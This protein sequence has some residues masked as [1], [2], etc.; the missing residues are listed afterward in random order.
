[1]DKIAQIS[2]AKSSIIITT[3]N[4]SLPGIIFVKYIAEYLL[5][6]IPI[7]THDWEKFISPETL[8][9]EARNSG[10][11]LDD[12]TGIIPNPLTNDFYLGPM[13][14]LNYAASGMIE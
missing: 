12:F 2:N 7:G 8:F 13:L 5:K 3:I 9:V 6:L 14:A 11:I 10:I 1:M 4:K